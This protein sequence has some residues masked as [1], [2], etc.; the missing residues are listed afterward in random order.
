MNIDFA[1][2]YKISPTFRMVTWGLF[3]IIVL[4]IAAS[5]IFKTE[6]IVKGEARTLPRGDVWKIVAQSSGDVVDYNIFNGKQVKKGELLIALDDSVHRQNINNVKQNLNEY[7]CLHDV[8]DFLLQQDDAVFY[9]EL[10]NVNNGNECVAFNISL[11]HKQ[12]F[13][14]LSQ[15]RLQEVQYG[16][17]LRG[18]QEEKLL[19]DDILKL[20][21]DELQRKKS[22]LEQK[23]ISLSNYDEVQKTYL[24]LKQRA[25]ELDVNVSEYE[26]LLEQSIKDRE[27]EINNSRY[28]WSMNKLNLQQDMNDNRLMVNQEEYAVKQSRILAPIDGIIDNKK[29]NGKGDFVQASSEV[30][31]IIPSGQDLI[32]RVDFLNRD[33]GLIKQD[34]EAW[35]KLDAFPM[36]RYELLKGKVIRVSSESILKG[37]EWFYSIDIELEKQYIMQNGVRYDLKSGMTGEA[38]II[39]GKRRFIAFLF[40]PIVRALH[41]VAKEP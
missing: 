17:Q 31:S 36:E 2:N 37:A 16:N 38:D 40:E 9:Q 33:I 10:D 25:S 32:V 28:T 7:Q 4:G 34:Q 26:Y 22:L 27:M 6:I 3:I 21:A 39:V 14:K 23:L 19:L 15:L 1:K 12:I 29:V 20:S 35:V 41:E 24:Q 5:I 8:Y 13:K 11:Q 30:L 18:L